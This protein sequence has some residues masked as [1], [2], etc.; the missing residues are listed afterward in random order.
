MVRQF[1]GFSLPPKKEKTENKA[2]GAF[3]GLHV[4]T[5]RKLYAPCQVDR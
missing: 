4:M 5:T 1:P 2:T 3:S